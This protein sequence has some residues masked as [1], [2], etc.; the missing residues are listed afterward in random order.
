MLYVIIAL[1]VFGIALAGYGKIMSTVD[2][3]K[4]T[5]TVSKNMTKIAIG[6]LLMF[7][8]SILLIITYT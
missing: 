5:D 2:G 7:L 8:A 1:F 3:I 4:D 6:V